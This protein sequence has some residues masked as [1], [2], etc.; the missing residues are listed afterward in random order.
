[1][2]GTVIASFSICTVGICTTV[3]RIILTLIDIYGRIKHYDYHEYGYGCNIFRQYTLDF[4]TLL[5]IIIS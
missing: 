3:V 5:A 4:L 2:A 1:M